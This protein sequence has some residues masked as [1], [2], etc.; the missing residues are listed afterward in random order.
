MV[1]CGAVRCGVAE[2]QAGRTG[3]SYTVETVNAGDARA[4]NE[5]DGKQPTN[6]KHEG[7]REG[8]TAVLRGEREGKGQ[9]NTGEIMRGG[10]GGRRQT[11]L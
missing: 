7:Q 11:S 3:G 8:K 1:C 9:A 2:H 10:T 6:D 5:V 4:S